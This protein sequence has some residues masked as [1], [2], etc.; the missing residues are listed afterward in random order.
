MK[1][2]CDIET[3]RL[4]DPDQIW[5]IVCRDVSKP[6]EPIV[7]R[8]VTSDDNEKKRFIEFAKGVE[9]W[10]GHNFLSFDMVHINGLV[11]KDL[12]LPIN[13]VDT[14]VVSR[15]VEYSREG[16]HSLEQYG[17]EFGVP[18]VLH[19]DY[20][21]YNLEL[22]KRCTIDTY[23]NH[24]LYKKLLKYISSTIWY[25]SILL[26]HQIVYLCNT[27]SSNGF[28]IDTKEARSLLSSIESELSTLDKDILR[29]FVPKPKLVREITPSYT[30]HGTLHKKD[31]KWVKDGDLTQFNG[32]P[33]SL[34]KWVEFN[35]SSPKQV[36]EVLHEAGWRPIDKTKGHIEL[37]REIRTL[38]RE[39][40]YKK[41]VD[42]SLQVKYDKLVEYKKVGWKV[43][44]TNLQTLPDT[45]PTPAK[46]IAKRILLESRRRTL[47]EWLELARQPSERIHGRFQHIGAW[48]HRMS[49]QNPN[50]A[51]IPTE[52]KLFGKEMRSLWSAPS[53]RLLVGVDA[54]GI[55]L[56]VLAHYI[57]DEEFT[58]ALVNGRKQDGTDPHSLNKRVIGDICKHRQNAKR[59]IYALVLGA[60]LD[61]LAEVLECSKEEAQEAV[62]RIMERYQGWSELKKTQVASDAK[63]GY[64]QGFDGR[65]VRIPGESAGERKH[66]ML[67]GYLQN[68]EA[69]VM[70]KACVHWHERLTKEKVPFK[71]VD[72]VHDEWQTETVN[73]LDVAKYIAQVQADSI[74]WAGEQLN[75]K[76]PMAG[77]VTSD[78]GIFEHS[79]EWNEKDQ[80]WD[81]L[82]WG[83]GHNWYQTH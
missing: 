82:Y 20:S 57:E 80:S 30:K 2:V 61:K 18:K 24:L 39:K 15:L 64:F 25:K 51:N 65:Y 40:K 53:D 31:F 73:D 67:S 7:F 29:V 60:G 71:F 36:V 26:E 17:V 70:K 6:D 47:V 48:T 55:Q 41:G 16:G 32:G 69:I 59:F 21:S 58:N 50:T 3:N 54:E 78:H 5:V 66:L 38:E 81:I 13:V 28:R 52:Q 43:N 45:A 72:F 62:S 4:F 76:C 44:E 68:G 12:I 75:L 23:I 77:A 19:V 33:F 83:I 1:V 10:I 56:R 14:L 63:R 35:P 27:L 9:T 49:H 42:T 37:E 22:E 46:T 79:R 34:L 11:E 8:H 74:K